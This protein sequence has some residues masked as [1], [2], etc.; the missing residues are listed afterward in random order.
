MLETLHSSLFL[1]QILARA[2]G[3]REDVVTVASAWSHSL[4]C[5]S[6]LATI[7][8]TTPQDGEGGKKRICALRFVSFLD[9]LG[10]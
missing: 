6:L 1:I 7:I 5:L 9:D 10:S 3:V 2:S 4:I 8:V